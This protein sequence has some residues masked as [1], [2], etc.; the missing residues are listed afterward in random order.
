MQRDAPIQEPLMRTP[1]PATLVAVVILVGTASQALGQFH[2][3]RLFPS[4]TPTEPSAEAEKPSPWKALSSLKQKL[5]KLNPK[6]QQMSTEVVGGVVGGAVA[7]GAFGSFAGP[8]G[9]VIGAAGG[10]LAG[11]VGAAAGTTFKDFARRRLKWQ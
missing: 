4:K 8:A 9:T 7:G 1:L 3:P 5:P 10:A 6:E 2:L 11:G